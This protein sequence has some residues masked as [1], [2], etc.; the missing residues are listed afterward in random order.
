M[1]DYAAKFLRLAKQ[2]AVK[3]DAAFTEKAGG[4]HFNTGRREFPAADAQSAPKLDAD[5]LPDNSA[6]AP[7]A[8][9]IWTVTFCRESS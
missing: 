3:D 2:R 5:H 6:M 9:L 4:V 7:E 8:S 1:Q